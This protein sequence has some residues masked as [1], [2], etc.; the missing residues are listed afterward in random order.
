MCLPN[1]EDCQPCGRCH[2]PS[3]GKK[4]VGGAVGDSNVEW[5]FG[6]FDSNAHGVSRVH[7]VQRKIAVADLRGGCHRGT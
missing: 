3:C 6:Q 2:F 5:M 4:V 1:V 7:L